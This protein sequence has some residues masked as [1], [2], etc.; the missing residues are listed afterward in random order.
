M[1]ESLKNEW[2]LPDD[3]VY[4][5]HG[6]FGPSPR[7]VQDARIR[8][9]RELERQPMEFLIRRTEIEL[10]TTCT[11]LGDLVGCDGDDLLLIDNATFAMNIVANSIQL[12]TGDE[13]LT[14]NHEYGSVTRLWRRVCQSAGAKLVV[15]RTPEPLT[16]HAEFVDDFF[17]SV[18]EKTRV[19][20]LS[21]VTS[22]TATIFP[23][24]AICQRARQMKIITCIDGPH[25]LAMLPLNMRR[26]Q[27]DFYSA[28]CHKWLSAPFG[29]GF[30]YVRKKWQQSLQPNMISWGGSVAGRPKS[31]KDEFQWIG[32]RDSAPLIAVR[33]A[34]DFLNQFGFERFR[35]Y[36]HDLACY[37]RS[38]VESRTSCRAVTPNTSE[39]FGPMLSFSLPKEDTE[40][41]KHG[42]LDPIQGRLQD[43]NIEA[44]V[45]NWNSQRLLRVSCYLYN[46]RSDIDD[47]CWNDRLV[48][49]QIDDTYAPDNIG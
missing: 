36:T 5:N 42:Q 26:M 35:E 38:E 2:T 37:L 45:T 47:L 31:W 22:S 11:Q 14:S 25:A 6:S 20:L 12:Q 48:P 29:S 10:E 4:L 9:Y 39:W 17:E 30:L 41:P 19:I 21:H 18:T 3:V 44:P 8:W 33:D 16:T 15:H 40:A 27:C 13:V 43:F 46:D 1:T 32:T 23:V 24:D 34:I 28:S 7:C 49:N